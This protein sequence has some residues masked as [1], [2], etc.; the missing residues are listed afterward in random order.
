[1]AMAFTS[2]PSLQLKA[3]PASSLGQD[4][5]LKSALGNTSLKS[6]GSGIS[7]GMCLLGVVAPKRV[8]LFSPVPDQR[9]CKGTT[10]TSTQQMPFFSPESRHKVFFLKGMAQVLVL[11]LCR[12]VT[13]EPGELPGQSLHGE[14][15]RNT[16]VLS[17]V[18]FWLFF[19]FSLIPFC[20]VSQ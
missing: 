10:V 6:L 2:L 7:Q 8:E 17:Q 15:E 14:R 11:L 5:S 18:F 1:M 12:V 19:F 9:S 20:R 3:P 16:M 4:P 13:Q